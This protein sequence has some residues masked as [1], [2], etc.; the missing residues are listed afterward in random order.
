MDNVSWSV[1]F[2]S[3]PPQRGGVFHKIKR[4]WQFNLSQQLI[5]QK[6]LWRKIHMNRMVIVISNISS[7]GVRMVKYTT[8]LL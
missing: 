4:S 3:G 1:G 6:V 2:A 8:P 5:Y 7:V